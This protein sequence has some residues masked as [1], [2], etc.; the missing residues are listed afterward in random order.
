MISWFSSV[1][2]SASFGT[3]AAAGEKA[4]HHRV[5]RV[6]QHEALALVEHGPHVAVAHRGL[7]E[8]QQRVERRERGGG[9]EHL[10]GMRRD[11]A[12]DLLVDGG[13]QL[14]QP[15]ARAEHP[16]LVLLQLLRV[17]PLRVDER[18]AADVVLRHAAAMGVGDLQIVAE[19]LV[20]ADLQVGDAGA[21]ALL[22][23]QPRD[24]GARVLRGHPHL[25]HLLGVPLADDS[26]LPHVALRVVGDGRRYALHRARARVQLRREPRQAG[27]GILRQRAQRRN[28]FQ[29]AAQPHQFARNGEPRADTLH[30]ALE[31][32]HLGQL[33]AYPLA[34]DVR[35]VQ[36]RHGVEAAFQRVDVEQRLA[37]PPPEQARA[38]RRLRLVQ[39]AQ[40]RL[41]LRAP[42]PS[43][44]QFEVPPRL[45]VERH[46]GVGR[47]RPQA[48]QQRQRRRVR[49]AH[50]VQHDR[51]RRR[52]ELQPLAAEGV[53]RPHAEVV[54]HAPP[55]RVRR[56]RSA[57]H[58][59]HVTLLRSRHSHPSGH[60]RSSRH[61]REGGNLA[62]LRQQQLRRRQPRDLLRYRAGGQLRHR[63]LA[64]SDV[65]ERDAG[66]R[67]ARRNR[68]EVVVRAGVQHPRLDDRAGRHHAHHVPAHERPA[69]RFARLLRDGDA[70]PLP[71]ELGEVAVQSVVRD[72]RERHHLPL[73]HVA[74][75]Q[76]DLQVPRR[77]PGVLVERLVEV[78][79]AVQQQRIRV[80]RLYLQVLLAN[81][82]GHRV[83]LVRQPNKRNAPLS[84]S[85]LRGQ[86][87]RSPPR[88]LGEV[89]AH[90]AAGEGCHYRSAGRSGVSRSNSSRHVSGCTSMY[91]SISLPSGSRM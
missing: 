86:E 89:D 4:L 88:P 71:H 53:Q 47:V 85:F 81:G 78:A 40:E 37:E 19:H 18:L 2:R 65:H 14:L 25:V 7:G 3:N 30:H 61:S 57:L 22:P 35:L 41:P 24:V 54:E 34:P 70:V 45:R 1:D 80:A 58:P 73:S 82:A 44:E 5:A 43:L 68:R 63:E 51:R 33:R 39:H 27:S 12:A 10:R 74:L 17:E 46:E 77:E 76:H 91:S 90:C 36:P 83:I 28:A 79:H 60:S 48:G 6:A 64:G 32:R 20:V 26:P 66:L 13:L 29:R 84:P 56:E 75:R 16:V 87:P 11:L 15:V 31:V 72:A 52:R 49:S 55:R 23:L 69:V 59:R 9:P 42:A 62:P 67:A 8:R 21:L 38:H 50:V